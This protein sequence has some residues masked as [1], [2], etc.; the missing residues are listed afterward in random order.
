MVVEPHESRRSLQRV[1]SAV[2]GSKSEELRG[3]YLRKKSC[4][5]R[6]LARLVRCRRLFVTGLRD[7]WPLGDGERVEVGTSSVA[8]T[9]LVY[10]LE[11]YCTCYNELQVYEYLS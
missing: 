9:A 4:L 7:R 2:P 1:L 11:F 8:I 3:L 6:S 5:S 10:G